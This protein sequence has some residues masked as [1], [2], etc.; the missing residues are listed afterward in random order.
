MITIVRFYANAKDAEKAVA[1]LK[2]DG[3]GADAINH[4]KPTDE[5]DPAARVGQAI[6]AGHLPEFS[7][8][9]VSQALGRKRHVVSIS[10][11][12]G[13]ARPAIRVL[14]GC[15]PVDEEELPESYSTLE[16]L[17]LMSDILAIPML[18]KRRHYTVSSSEG[19]AGFRFVFA[20]VLGLGLLSSKAAPL[21]NAVGMK[22]LSEPKK[23]WHTSMGMALKSD[24]PAPLS[25][26]LGMKTVLPR[27]TEWT[28]SFGFPLLSSSAAP[29]S[30]A[31]GL[32]VLTEKKG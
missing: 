24:D 17:R 19:L 16:G 32:P 2:A 31:F 27:K 7:K 8:S 26:K 1:N 4:I 29:F 15:N 6:D 22:T 23:D 25:S 12:Y 13:R 21:S 20:N 11:V 10:V 28:S 14:E 9:T 30:K 3:F 18:S 5:G